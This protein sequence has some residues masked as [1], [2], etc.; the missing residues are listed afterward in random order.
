MNDP[1]LRELRMP[2]GGSPGILSRT[3]LVLDEKQ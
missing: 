2:S 3:L 1:K